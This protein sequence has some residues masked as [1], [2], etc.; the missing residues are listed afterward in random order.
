MLQSTMLIACASEERDL[1]IVERAE[2]IAPTPETDDSATPEEDPPDQPGLCADSSGIQGAGVLSLDWCNRVSPEVPYVSASDT[3]GLATDS[4]PPLDT[5]ILPPPCG[6][7]NLIGAIGIAGSPD[8]PKLLYCDTDPDG[9][10]WLLDPV[11]GKR[12]LLAPLVCGADSHTGALLQSGSD[13]WIAWTGSP[14]V[15]A[16]ISQALNLAKI[17]DG[18]VTQ[19]GYTEVGSGPYQVELL[20]PQSALLTDFD[21]SLYLGD[22]EEQ[23]WQ[24]VDTGVEGAAGVPMADGSSLIATCREDGSVHLLNRSR[25]I[26]VDG[27][28]GWW[29]R[30]A[31]ATNGQDLALAWDDGQAGTIAFFD[32]ELQERGRAALGEGTRA[33]ALTWT[34]S[35]FVSFSA[36]GVLAFWSG[37]G[38]LLRT[39]IHPGAA[40]AEVVALRVEASSEKLA[41]VVVGSESYKLGAGHINTYQT[42]EI[43]A[44]SMP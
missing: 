40:H 26:P 10:L 42:V 25:D 15:R 23:D 41:F 34:G 24:A 5:G 38:D 2:T 20:P 28:C 39:A 19:L 17:S 22:L 36:D 31:L 7:V 14:A 32:A 13:T 29:V 30:P 27:V 8:K 16:P 21:G 6:F 9:G 43:S 3:G 4:A 37:E 1:Q 35:E 33:N 18:T 11:E 44:A 12:D